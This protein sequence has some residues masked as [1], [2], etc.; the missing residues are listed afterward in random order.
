MGW[1]PAGERWTMKRRVWPNT[2][3]ASGEIQ[4]PASSG[5]RWR[6]VSRIRRRMD[7]SPIK[8]DG[9]SP[10]RKK[11]QIPHTFGTPEARD[12]VET[13]ALAAGNIYPA[14]GLVQK[15]TAFRLRLHGGLNSNS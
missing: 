14:P 10:K 2:N 1:W 5:P 15:L 4:M 8:D 3:L 9:G 13:Q 12:P 11:P 7:S 6:G